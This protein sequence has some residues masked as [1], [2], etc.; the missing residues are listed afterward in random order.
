MKIL[1]IGNY[2]YLYSKS[3]DK[4]ANL[5]YDKLTERG[6]IVRLLKPFPI[7]GKIK[8]SP[9]GLGKW[10][11]YVDRFF[12]FIPSLKK[13]VSW[14]DIINIC[15]QANAVY[16]PLVK[17]KPH[18]VTCHDV[19]AIQNAC[20]DF[21]EN[22]I[23]FFG[24]LFQ[25]WILFSLEKSKNIICV[26]EKTK[27]DFIKLSRNKFHNNIIVI[28]NGM[29]YPFQPLKNEV[30]IDILEQFGINYSIPFFIHVGSNVWRKNKR[31]LFEITAKLSELWKNQIFNLVLVGE[32]LTKELFDYAKSLGIE[33]RI[34]QVGKISDRELQALYSISKGLIF[35][36]IA[37]GFGWP[38]I[39]AQA[40]GC[41]VFTTNRSP[42]TEI[43]GKAAIYFDIEDKLSA[44]KIIYSVLNNP[45]LLS[46]M[47]KNGYENAKQYSSDIMI[48]NIEKLYTNII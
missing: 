33:S 23:K 47:K 21:Y 36:S 19:I 7:L 3:M 10:L 24:R 6:H 26:S 13:A 28:K 20:G 27:Q 4:Y 16:L 32:A 31:G 17:E 46:E 12:L 22:T 11:G 42:M 43:G 40:C 48:E 39:E 9:N 15:D 34:I 45:E 29:N 35:P 41:P 14:A 30:A 8:P 2:P 5:L 44:A 37:E 25:K 1:L 18:V 38:I